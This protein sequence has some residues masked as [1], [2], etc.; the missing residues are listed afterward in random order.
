MRIRSKLGIRLARI[1]G[2][3]SYTYTLKNGVKITTCNLQN[4]TIMWGTSDAY[5]ITTLPE[6]ITVIFRWD[7]DTQKWMCESGEPK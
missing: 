4:R 6:T 3:E 2:K 7:S 1:R 5:K